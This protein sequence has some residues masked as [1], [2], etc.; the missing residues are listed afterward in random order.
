MAP[1]LLDQPVWPHNMVNACR[2]ARNEAVKHKRGS[3][4]VT[5]EK[6]TS[7]TFFINDCKA[8]LIVPRN[9]DV[10]HVHNE[11]IPT[12]VMGC[13]GCGEEARKGG[14]GIRDI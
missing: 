12:T 8:P 11:G 4:T 10:V 14:V 6:G 9:L 13:E 7:K 2:K 3:Y 1:P 5:N